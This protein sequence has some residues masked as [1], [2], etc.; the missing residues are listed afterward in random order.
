MSDKECFEEKIRESRG[1]TMEQKEKQFAKSANK[2]AMG[3]W[4]VMLIV[5]S[6]AYIFEIKKGLKSVE[7]YIGLELLCWVP[8]IIGLIVLKVK[9]WHTKAYQDI[10][11]TGFGILYLYIMLTAPG[12]L[13]FTYILPIMSMLIIYKNRNFIIRCGI[14]AIAVVV[15]TIIRNYLNG[16]NT[17]NDISNF[18]IQFFIIV[19]CFV[20]Y[21]IAINHM[22][23]SDNAML[24]EVKSNLAKVV[25]TVEQVKVASSSVVDGVTV[26]R[27]LADENK[28]GAT[29]VVKSMEELSE[30]N[31]VLGQKV[32]S[33]MEMTED[34]DNQVGN[35]AELVEKIVTLSEKSANH[36]GNSSKELENAVEATNVMVK[37]SSDVEHILNE[38]KEQFDKVKQETGTIETITSQTNLLS[39]NASIEAARAGEAG[40]GFAVVADEIRNL[41]MG[42]QNSSSSI[43][44]ALSHLEE[45]S[46]KMTESIGTILKLITE[47]LETIKSVNTSV[48]VIAEDSKQLGNE[49]RV[50]DTAMKQVENANKNMVDNMREVQDIMVTMTESVTESENTTITMLSKYEETARNVVN[51][52]TVVGKLVEELGA[53]GFMSLEDVEK[54]MSLTLI[55]VGTKREYRTEI[56]DVK[57][58]KVFVEASADLDKFIAEGGNKAKYDAHVVVNNTV[59]IWEN[60]SVDKHKDEAT[61]CYQLYVEG[62]PRV[63]NRRKHPRLSMNNKCDILLRAK[64]A[65]FMGNIVNISAGGFAFVCKAE[66]F[67]RATG[68]IVRV[69]I[70]DFELLKGKQL[71][72][73]IIRSSNDNG[74]Y[75][76]GCRMPEDNMAI[77]EY[78]KDRV[79]E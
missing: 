53:G 15:G 27:E 42:T 65:T 32:D 60:S 22:T 36:A 67:A 73:I 52:E 21:I 4:L 34:I 63:L 57:G 24:D 17:S 29:A 78:V 8:F 47:T 12:T 37:L 44:Q 10:V 25:T 7:F 75:I 61:G 23:M 38:F 51:I 46:D 16:M 30:K 50:V 49:I 43:M 48:G 74:T 72:G 2:K 77:L 70:H 3:M 59:Y 13:A 33:S 56:A 69:T 28:E 76:V 54:G 71:T 66:E 55:E 39:L 18:E 35:V 9:G 40:R 1:L 62:K 19:F 58:E 6:V 31:M 20:G 5:L 45:T 68:E 41:S 64:D 14:A 79:K 26:V 11:G